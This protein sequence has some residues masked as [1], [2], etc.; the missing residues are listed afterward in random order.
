MDTLFRR[1][2]YEEYIQKLNEAKQ[3]VGA[4]MNSKGITNKIDSLYNEVKSIGDKNESTNLILLLAIPL[5]VVCLYQFYYY[6]MGIRF[7][8]FVTLFLYLVMYRT[9]LQGVVKK[10]QEIPHDT[11]D[12]D[13]QS[14]LTRVDYLENGLDI[15]KTRI[16]LTRNFY[17]LFFPLLMMS[18]G[19][20]FSGP[21]TDVQ[22]W[23]MLAIAF[24]IGGGFWYK[25]FD[26]DLQEIE[27]TRD[28]LSDIRGKLF[29]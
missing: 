14:L 25:Y 15:K 26:E 16:T 21:F 5:F 11:D 1:R 4:K 29:S 7:A 10:A 22:Y 20:M 23:V 24:V 12:H 6:G 9:K 17:V 3:E 19:E 18:L 27:F 13:P 2:K 8:I 28:D